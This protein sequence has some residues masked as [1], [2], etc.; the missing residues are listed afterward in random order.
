MAKDPRIKIIEDSVFKDW[1]RYSWKDLDGGKHGLR[2]S[3]YHF[4]SWMDAYID[5]KRCFNQYAEYPVY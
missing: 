5:A 3:F 2:T 1:N 4:D